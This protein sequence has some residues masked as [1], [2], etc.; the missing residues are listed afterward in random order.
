MPF[1]KGQ[2]K[3]PGSGR[4]PGSTNKLPSSVVRGIAEMLIEYQQSGKMKEDFDAL[5]SKDRIVVA[6]KY[7]GYIAPRRQAVDGNLD[8]NTA[9]SNLDETLTALAEENE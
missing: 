2:Q 7:T 8:I 6:E 3:T 4:K 5:D 9:K 1:K